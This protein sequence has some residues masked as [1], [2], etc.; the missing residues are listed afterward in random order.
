M[1]LAGILVLALDAPLLYLG[2]A[3][4]IPG[5]FA[6]LVLMSSQFLYFRGRKRMEGGGGSKSGAAMTLLDQDPLTEQQQLSYQRER[7]KA[8]IEEPREEQED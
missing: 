6:I 8:A 5:L 7:D 4:L 3:L 2:L 1:I